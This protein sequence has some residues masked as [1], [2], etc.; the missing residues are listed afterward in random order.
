MYYGYIYTYIYL[1]LLSVLI[2]LYNLKT[3]TWAIHLLADIIVTDHEGNLQLENPGPMSLSGFRWN[4]LRCC[5]S[6]TCRLPGFS[7]PRFPSHPTG[8]LAARGGGKY[9][10]HQVLGSLSLP[11][12]TRPS[13]FHQPCGNG[14]LQSVGVVR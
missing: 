8:T 5:Q 12:R 13:T 10:V 11:G 2:N 4:R 14:P 1:L 6:R 7:T 3:K 9:P